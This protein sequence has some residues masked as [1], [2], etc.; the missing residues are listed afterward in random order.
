MG[1]FKKRELTEAER[2]AENYNILGRDKRVHPDTE[3]EEEAEEEEPEP[4]PEPE[5]ALGD[6]DVASLKER[7]EIL[8][9]KQTGSRE[10]L[11]ER[12]EEAEYVSEE[13]PDVIEEDAQKA[14][15]RTMDGKKA[16][17]QIQANRN[18]KII[19][20]EKAAAQHERE[21]IAMIPKPIVEVYLPPPPLVKRKTGCLHA[22][23]DRYI[24]GLGKY[25]HVDYSEFTPYLSDFRHLGL[26][27]PDVC[28]LLNIFLK[29][30]G[31][32]SGHMD[33]FEFFMW[34]DIGAD[35]A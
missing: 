10:E 17:K 8:G 4:E 25:K 1:L 13:E 12:I 15:Q 27:E 30:D 11:L 31:D 19:Q 34:A 5:I 18:S 26:E 33:A 35:A 2:T 28:R 29:I 20:A 22:C 32:R 16:K 24:L 9:L 14:V 21:R 6:L 23:Y 7:A 3:S